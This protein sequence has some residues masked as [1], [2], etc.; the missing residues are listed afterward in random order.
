MD[1]SNDD[2]FTDEEIDQATEVFE[3]WMEQAGPAE[4]FKDWAKEQNLPPK[5]G[6]L[7]AGFGEDQSSRIPIVLHNAPFMTRARNLQTRLRCPA[8]RK[9]VRL[10]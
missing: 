6:E 8:A 3:K 9:G 5:I 1:E 2:E 4:S 7:L 10:H